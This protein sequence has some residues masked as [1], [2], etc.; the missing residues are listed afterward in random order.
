MK[1]ST[2]VASLVMAFCMAGGIAPLASAQTPPANT[3]TTQTHHHPKAHGAAAGAVIG[4]A[5]TGNAAKG[6]AIG[7]G[8]SRR[9][10]RRANR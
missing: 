2:K 9:E 7:A 10:A 5:T 3:G 4:A 6:A 8:H 1:H